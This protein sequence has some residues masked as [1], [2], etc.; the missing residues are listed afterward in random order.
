MG[1]NA[2]GVLLSIFSRKEVAFSLKGKAFEKKVVRLLKKKGLKAG[3]YKTSRAGEEYDYDALLLWGD[4]LFLFECKNR[5]LPYD[6]PVRVRNFQREA[7]KQVRQV[8]RLRAA[9]DQWP[10]IIEEALGEP[11]GSRT[12]VP[13][14]LNN[15]PYARSGDTEGVHFYDY[16][17]LSRFFSSR[18]LTFQVA[19]GATFE[20]RAKVNSA[21]LWQGASPQPEDLLA[22]LKDPVQL[23]VTRGLTRTSDFSFQLDSKTAATEPR[24]F[25]EDMT[26]ESIGLALGI[27]RHVMKAKVRALTKKTK[28][29]KKRKG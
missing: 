10:E 20:K 5:S 12:V 24:L 2:S 14:V 21:K 8:Q 25:R 23:R 13:V 28:K 17:A 27:P 7:R 3:S 22:Q 9:L 6:N 11:L 1:V 4:Y 29:Q 16:P 19:T 18:A 15:L 26:P